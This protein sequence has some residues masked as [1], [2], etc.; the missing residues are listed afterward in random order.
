MKRFCF[1]AFVLAGAIAPAARAQSSVTLYGIVDAG[2]LYKTHAATG[3]GSAWSVASG[4]DSTSRWGLTGREDLG[5]GLQAL[6]ELESAFRVNTG[7]NINGGQP[8]SAG[9]VLF[10]RGATV[11]IGSK[12]YGNVLL[13]KN[14]SP[15]LRIQSRLDI[16]GYSNFGSLNNLLYQ[17]L[18]GYTGYQYSWV[19]NSVEYI[20]PEFA[21]FQGMA[22][23][24]FGGTA[25]NF[26]NKSVV[27][28]GASYK[29]GGF[30][31]GA[32]YFNG[33][34]ITGATDSTTARAYTVGANYGWDAFKVMLDFA[35]FKNPARGTSDNFYTAEFSY[36][37]TPFWTLS[38]TYIRQD[39]RVTNDRDASLYKLGAV[40][41]LSRATSVYS[42]IGYVK[43][44][45]L[46]TLGLQNSTPAGVPGGNQFGAAIGIRHLF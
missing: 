37:P 21:G 41:S 33:R 32:S 20:S 27:S 6:F 10:D 40:Y 15:I 39:D 17:N 31:A 44:N 36:T 28:L 16:E 22:M 26:S 2:V 24:S 45:R 7:Q 1:A 42:F 18:S 35:N 46:A 12:T 13:G 30:L 19:D 5:G 9:T 11:G 23:Y 43:N 14:R 4:I 25:G 3:G 38:A 29:I 34:D 8:A